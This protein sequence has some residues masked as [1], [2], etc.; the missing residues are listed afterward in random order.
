MLAARGSMPKAAKIIERTWRASPHPDL[1]TVY[2]YVRPG[3]SPRDRL[4]RL[5]RLARLA[6]HS[7]E[8]PIAIATAAI[9]GRDWVEARSVLEPLLAERLSQRVCT[10]MAKLEGGE[11]GDTGRVREW[12]ARAVNAPRDPA[13]TADGVVAERWDAISPVTGALDRFEWKVPPAVRSLATDEAMAK[14][15]ELVALGT[16]EGPVLPPAEAREGASGDVEP[17]VDEPRSSS[18]TSA[19]ASRKQSQPRY[20]TPPVQPGRRSPAAQSEDSIEVAISQ[21]ETPR[22]DPIVDHDARK[23][24]TEASPRTRVAEP[25]SPVIIIGRDSA[26]S[27][28]DPSRPNGGHAGTMAHRPVVDEQSSKGTGSTRVTDTASVA[29]SSPMTAGAAN[30]TNGS[31]G[32]SRPSGAS[33]G[34]GRSDDGTTPVKPVAASSETPRT[35]PRGLA[36]S[37]VDKR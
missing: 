33:A 1:A 15:E 6:P 19:E 12:L 29:P 20:Y 4:E 3:D 7:V 28:G 10:L 17:G 35:E 23:R 36:S 30:G 22:T 18:A 31:H 34:E 37:P 26:A 14:M 11:H 25:A 9:E 16:A 13:W 2:A 32:K 21:N 5:R 24:Q 27:A 8:G